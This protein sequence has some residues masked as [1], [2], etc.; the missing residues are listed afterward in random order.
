MTEEFTPMDTS[1]TALNVAVR[2][3]KVL[4]LGPAGIDVVLSVKEARR[5]LQRLADA[6]AVAE[7]RTPLEPPR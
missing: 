1:D 6:I 4:I 5:S 3:D 7:G 2:G